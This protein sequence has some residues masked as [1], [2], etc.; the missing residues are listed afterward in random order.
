MTGFKG[1]FALQTP[2]DLLRK[3]QH[4][5]QRLKD[6]PLNPYPAF[7]FF[8]TAEHMLGWVYP[9][10]ANRQQRTN[11]RNSNVLLQVCSHIANGSKHFEL[12]DTRH[13]SVKD[14]SVHQG[15]FQTGAFQN[16][17]FDVSELRIHLE[18]D[19]ASQ[20]GQYVGVLPLARKALDYWEAIL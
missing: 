15:A 13:K 12:N 6:D 18:G 19:A 17:A 9:G 5:Y 11:L 8:V 7:D 4:D 3:L 16:D 20:L 1:F 10:Y 2:Q 14:A